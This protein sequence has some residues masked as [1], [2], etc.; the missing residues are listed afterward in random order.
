M[1]AGMVVHFGGVFPGR[2]QQAVDAFAE[3]TKLYGEKLA[4]GTFTSFEPYLYETGDI[5]EQLGFFIV[6][7]SQEKILDFIDS[8]ESAELRTKVAQICTHLQ[9]ELLYTGSRVLEQVNLLS[10]LAERIEKMPA[11]VG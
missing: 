1:E 2:E 8:R 4:E 9:I 6:K 5:R 7:G 3:T 10:D 11:G